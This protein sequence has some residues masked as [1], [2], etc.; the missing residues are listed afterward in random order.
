MTSRC[1]TTAT[2]DSPMRRTN[3]SGQL[4][5]SPTQQL[6]MRPTRHIPANVYGASVQY[7]QL[8]CRSRDGELLNAKQWGTGADACILIHGFGD[9]AYVWDRFSPSI[10]K[11]FKTL[12]VDLR[13]HGDSSW[14]PAGRYDAN[15]HV[16]DILDL[17]DALEIR[18]FV[19]VGHSLGAD[20]AIRIA[21]M[22]PSSVI[23]AVIIDFGPELNQEGAERVRRDFNDGACRWS[24]V[25]E[26]AA[27]L[28]ARRPLADPAMIE[29]LARGALRTDPDF[30][31]RLKCDP[32]LGKAYQAQ[33]QAEEL[34]EMLKR[35]SSPVL[36]IR[37][38]GSAVLSR[39]VSDRMER[40]L[41][42][43][44]SR[45]I[46][47]AGHAVMSD[48]PEGF[49]EALSPFLSQMKQRAWFSK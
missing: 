12:T 31:Y 25:R 40:V 28:Q 19:L 16:D 22:R 49:E 6:S 21:S 7:T 13:G 18:R 4:S 10:A 42:N 26:Y 34:W 2:V 30:G 20:V 39:E 32:A 38:I 1:P 43:A 47:G 45:T 9:G 46:C 15:G 48:N 33:Q 29:E 3:P 24:T 23:G 44:T 14:D 8:T 41:Q 17:V 5:L 37:G 27:W 36:V 11:L 35:I